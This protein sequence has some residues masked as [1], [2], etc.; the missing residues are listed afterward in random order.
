MKYVII[1][2][3]YRMD[4]VYETNISKSD[5]VI[6]NPQ[7]VTNIQFQGAFLSRISET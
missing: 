6:G 4:N 3:P 5:R 7:G 2:N 1:E